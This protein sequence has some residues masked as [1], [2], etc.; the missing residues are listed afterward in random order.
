M[1]CKR[2]VIGPAIIEKR[3]LQKSHLPCVRQ[4]EVILLRM[5][6]KQDAPSGACFS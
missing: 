4:E 6:C 2:I 5:H 1:T 3:H